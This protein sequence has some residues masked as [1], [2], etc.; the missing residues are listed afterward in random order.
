[1]TSAATVNPAQSAKKVAQRPE[2]IIDVENSSDDEHVH[3]PECEHAEAH[4]QSSD[5]RQAGRKERAARKEISKAA[6]LKPMPHIKRV[7]FKR[8]NGPVFA[9]SNAEV[10]YDTVSGSFVVYGQPMVEQNGF[11]A[12]AAAAQQRMQQEAAGTGF[13]TSRVKIAESDDDA[14]DADG[15]KES[16][17]DAEV[18]ASGL[19]EKD[20]SIVM[21]QAH[22]S[23]A[24][25]VAALRA[26]S[27]D[28]VNTI[29]ELTM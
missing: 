15:G 6:N 20:I 24:R 2:K 8:H 13:E 21:S 25:A 28:I 9:V 14:G 26:N 23:R 18:D 7:T 19:D 10:Y 22:V 12:H 27:N 17:D 1:M 16:A 5:K 4:A 29:M 3:G 11:Q